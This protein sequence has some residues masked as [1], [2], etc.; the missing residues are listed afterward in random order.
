[1]NSTEAAVASWDA[2]YRRLRSQYVRNA[3]GR[4][5]RTVCSLN[6]V[7][8][9]PA[10]AKALT[11]LHREF[12]G[13]AGSGRIYGFD[14]VSRI[15]REAEQYVAAMIK[16]GEHPS[17]RDVERCRAFLDQLRGLFDDANEIPRSGD[18]P[19]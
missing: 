2:T 8:E 10:D 19:T 17:P 18:V 14:E 13:F 11:D 16:R 5:E 9:N 3:A 6:A 12:H 7:T 1:V 15:G 4:V